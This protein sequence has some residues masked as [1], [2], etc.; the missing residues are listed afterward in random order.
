MLRR[1]M[2]A[3]GRSFMGERF[4]SQAEADYQAWNLLLTQ[5]ADEVARNAHCYYKP[6]TTPVVAGVST[7]CSPEIIQLEGGFVFT[8]DGVMHALDVSTPQAMDDWFASWRTAQPQ[9]Q[10]DTL[11]TMGLNNAVLYPAP[12]YSSVVAQTTTLQLTAD[13]GGLVVSDPSRPFVAGAA[14]DGDV[15]L[16]LNITDG[17]GFIVGWYRITDVDELGNATLASGAGTAGSSQGSASLTSGGLW[18]EGPSV[19]GSSWDGEDN[20]CPLPERAHMAV[21]WQACAWRVIAYP[22]PENRARQPLIQQNLKNALGLLEHEVKRFT[23][24]TRVPSNVGQF[25]GPALP[26]SPLNMYG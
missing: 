7:Y 4:G 25:G 24:A 6:V 1:D 16:Y 14:P 2:F 5:G 18:L 10:P 21:V 13:G 23:T 9:D 12:N 3:L 11:I 8:A 22:T 15:G 20:P 17:L 26:F 19:P